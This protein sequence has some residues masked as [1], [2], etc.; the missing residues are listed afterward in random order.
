MDRIKELR[1]RSTVDGTEQPSLFYQAEGENRPLLVGLHTWSFD[2][3]NQVKAYLPY[4]E[5]LNWHLLLPEFRGANLTRNPHCRDAC[6]SPKAR[7]DILDAVEYVCARW[8]VDR[9]CIF[10]MGGSGGGHMTLMMCG[11]APTLWRGAVAYASITDLAAWYRE[12]DAAGEEYARNIAACM[13]G[14]TPD[15]VPEEYLARSPIGYVDQIA[16]ANLKMFHGKFDTLVP[17]AHSLNLYLRLQ[18]KY[19][20]ARTFLEIFSGE[21]ESCLPEGF[22]WLQKQISQTESEELSG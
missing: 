5:K 13:G 1:I 19:P 4:V 9:D 6:G 22:A 15:E 17:P 2:R 10:I 14:R 8:S 7:Q 3:F 18:E 21:H 16:K 11:T 12:T 20:Q